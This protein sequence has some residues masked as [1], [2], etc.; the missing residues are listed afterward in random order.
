M[1]GVGTLGR[2]TRGER[3]FDHRPGEAVRKREE[4]IAHLVLASAVAA[5]C[6]S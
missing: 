5:C 3:E 1:R 2:A 6:R 4:K